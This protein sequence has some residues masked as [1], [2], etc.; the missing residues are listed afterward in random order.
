VV[1]EDSATG[2]RAARNAAMRCYGYA[3]HD[4]GAQLSSEG[5]EV[6][7]HMNQMPELLRL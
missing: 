6:F 2:A 1:I 4:T 3:P 5:A 7:H